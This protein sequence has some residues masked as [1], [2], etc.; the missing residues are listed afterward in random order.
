[1]TKII[2]LEYLIKLQRSLIKILKRWREGAGKI[3]DAKK[4]DEIIPEICMKDCRLVM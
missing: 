3:L 2:Y 1:L 4:G